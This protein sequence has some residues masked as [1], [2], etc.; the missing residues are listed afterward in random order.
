MEPRVSEASNVPAVQPTMETADSIIAVCM[1]ADANNGLVTSKVLPDIP[2]MLVLCNSQLHDY[3]VVRL[4][5]L[6][7]AC[8]SDGRVYEQGNS[9][10][11][12][13]AEA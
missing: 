2:R 3:S 10:L 9:N 4:L 13:A 7:F 5:V 8:R 6:H 1:N 12:A 11:E